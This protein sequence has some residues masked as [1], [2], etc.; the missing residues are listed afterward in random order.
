M[1]EAA[2]SSLLLIILL[3]GFIELFMLSATIIDTHKIARE[4]AREAAL[5]GSIESGQA[6]AEDCVNQYF[7]GQAVALVYTNSVG[8]KDVNVVCTV[9]KPY[10]PVKFLDGVEVDINAEAVYPFQDENS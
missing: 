6:K 7:R 9:S 5:T 8:G 4:G 1:Y 10:K 2:L 3:L